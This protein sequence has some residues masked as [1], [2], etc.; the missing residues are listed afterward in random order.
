MS[1]STSIDVEQYSDKSFVLRG[2]GTRQ[3]KSLWLQY[4]GKFNPRLQG[5]AGYIFS[6]GKFQAIENLLKQIQ[7]GQL[8]PTDQVTQD[9]LDNAKIEYYVYQPQVGQGLTLE[10]GQHKVEYV[11]N[12]VMSK[13]NDRG[14]IDT[15]HIAPINT[16]TDNVSLLQ[17]VNGKWQIRGY[18]NEHDIIFN[19]NKTGPIGIPT[20]NMSEQPMQVPSYMLRNQQQQ[21]YPTQVQQVQQMPMQQ[22]QP[23]YQGQQPYQGQPSYHGQQPYQTQQP[24]YQNSTAP[25]VQQTMPGQF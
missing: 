24:P 21:T 11:V 20:I 16:D 6:M 12:D 23:S 7:A 22:V 13:D 19:P 3:Y 9:Q 18:M 15:V 2:G 17:I 14:I 10:V 1:S 8:P 4:G 5:G 25:F